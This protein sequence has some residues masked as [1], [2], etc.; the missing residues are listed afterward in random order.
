[1]QL[2]MNLID[3]GASGIEINLPEKFAGAE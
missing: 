3:A 2:Y 1:L